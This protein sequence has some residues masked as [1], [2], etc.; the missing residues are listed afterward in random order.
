MDNMHG[1]TFSAINSLRTGNAIIDMGIAMTV[2]AV[3]RTVFDAHRWES[4]KRYFLKRRGRGVRGAVRTISSIT[5]GHAG[6]FGHEQK[7]H[8][9][10][11]AIKLYLT[12]GLKVVPHKAQVQLTAMHDTSVPM[13]RQSNSK[14][15]PCANLRLTWIAAE[16]EFVAVGDEVV[17]RQYRQD[18]GSQKQEQG[19][20]PQQYLVFELSS[21]AAD[22]NA[23]IDA[24]IMAA[25]DFYRSEMGR[26]KDNDTRWMYTM[27]SG[28]TK[29]KR[30]SESTSDFRYKRYVLSD[31]KTFQSLFF[32]QKE[33]IL[34]L[35]SDFENKEGKFAVPGFP[36]KLGL[37]LHGPP[38]TGKTSFI[39]ALAQH[40]GRSII[41]ISLSQIE[42]N[43]QLSDVMYDLNLDVL[44]CDS[45]TRLQFKDVIFVI[46]DVDACSRVVRRRSEAAAAVGTAEALQLY[47]ERRKEPDVEQ[48]NPSSRDSSPSTVAVSPLRSSPMLAPP[49]PLPKPLMFGPPGA[50]GPF[51]PETST[52][53]G[54][55]WGARFRYAE[56]PDALNLAGLLNVLDGVVDTPGRLLVMT[57]NHPEVLDP[58]LIRP[59]RID[60]C[61]HLGYMADE[62]AVAMIEHYFGCPMTHGQRETLGRALALGQERTPASI[63]QLCAEF[64]TVD[65]LLSHLMQNGLSSDGP[66]GGNPAKRARCF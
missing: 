18:D 42:T 65:N 61:L 9:L 27:V 59:G 30:E 46:E 20:N 13:G 19:A 3:F 36:R 48:A 12:Q 21:E 22:G 24:F 60:R 5:K 53:P 41:N 26:L 17:F 28:E 45:N 31:E 40:T 14:D 23:R 2:P 57:S 15:D 50:D 62:D 63:E 43:M 52:V 33:S 64:D 8:L 25:L 11:K 66:Q 16:N 38:G 58:A 32:P 55:G 34:R 35:L 44:G 6:F 49:P 47:A 7:N 10:Q 1:A 56:S 51:P 54:D 29:R 4:L 39:K 37:L